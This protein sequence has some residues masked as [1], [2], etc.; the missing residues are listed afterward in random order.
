MK[1]LQVLAGASFLFAGSIAAVNGCSSVDDSMPATTGDSGTTDVTT[2]P[3]TDAGMPDTHVD[4][5]ATP[6]FDCTVRPHD[7]GADAGDAGPQLPDELYCTGLYSDW[8]AKT[9]APGILPF[10]AGV[11][12]WSDGAIKS[13]WISLPAGTKINSTDM[14]EWNFPVGTRLFKEFK[15]GTQRI[16]TRLFEKVANSGDDADWV[17]TVY[18]WAADESSAPKM[19]SGELN[20]NGT[21]YE[22]PAVAQCLTCHHGRK[23]KVLGFEAIGLGIPSADQTGVTLDKLVTGSLL[24]VN[25]ASSH[26]TIPEDF[27]G[28]AVGALGWLHANC[29]TSCHS[30]SPAAAAKFTPLHMR[31]TMDQVLPSDGGVGQVTLTDTYLTAVNK[32]SF[33]ATYPLIIK[34]H[35]PDNSYLHLRDLIR[36]PSDA[37]Y[38]QMPPIITHRPDDAGVAAVADWITGVN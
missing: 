5:D 17:F 36:D 27:T 31:L 29:G 35:D 15:L 23:D 18:R 14:D 37:G 34:S 21:G 8:G 4:I 24:T 7:A 32:A 16:E 3:P 12:L 25:P 2:E 20:V 28:K 19:E 9:V 10:N 11:V 33:S 30:A 26:L 1:R 6:P 38:T 22:V 13:R